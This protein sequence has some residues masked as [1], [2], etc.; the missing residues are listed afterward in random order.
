M[1][2]SKED[3]EQ[4]RDR[5][6]DAALK[7]FCRKGYAATSLE[8]VAREAALTR[9][10]VYH[11]FGGKVGLYNALIAAKTAKARGLSAILSDQSLGAAA[12][13]K[14]AMLGSLLLLGEDAEY[15]SVQ[16]L[17]LFKTAFAD[18]LAEGME[19]K[20]AGMAAMKA[21][22]WFGAEWLPYEHGFWR[23]KG[24]FGMGFSGAVK[25]EA[26]ERAV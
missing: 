9:G 7:V 13:L 21:K 16:D 10:A 19:M 26:A 12:R 6:I 1:K 25:S 8:D 14:A 3:A 2:R 15:R 23:A 22:A 5:L 17:I 11:H 20:R 18:E 24:W 4:T